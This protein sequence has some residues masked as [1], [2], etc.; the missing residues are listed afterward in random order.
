MKRYIEGLPGVPSEHPVSYVKDLPDG[1]V[2]VVFSPLNGVK[3]ENVFLASREVLNRHTVK[4]WKNGE[5]RT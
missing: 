1:R 4:R 5:E 2:C 3:P